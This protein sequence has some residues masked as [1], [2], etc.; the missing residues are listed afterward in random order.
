MRDRIHLE[1]LEEG[2]VAGEISSVMPEFFELDD[3]RA[4][5]SV[6]SPREEEVLGHKHE[7]CQYAFGT[8]LAKTSRGDDGTDDQRKGQ[9]K[10]G[11]VGHLNTL[12]RSS[13]LLTWTER[14]P[15]RGCDPPGIIS[16]CAGIADLCSPNLRLRS[17]QSHVCC[18]QGLRATAIGRSRPKRSSCFG[19]LLSKPSGGFSPASIRP[20][21]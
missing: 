2:R 15:W 4:L 18:W 13:C 12:T 10:C 7:L 14:C 21:G 20:S 16:E 17:S 19:E 8:G 9:E 3:I 5:L 11:Q 6:L 1:Q